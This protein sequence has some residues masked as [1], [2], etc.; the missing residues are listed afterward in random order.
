MKKPLHISI[1]FI[2]LLLPLIVTPCLAQDQFITSQLCIGGNNVDVANNILLIPGGGFLLTGES[3]SKHGDFTG[4]HGGEDF[5]VSWLK[6]NGQLKWAKQYG[7]SGDDVAF[8]AGN[9]LNG[10]AIAGITA[11]TDKD[12]IG[13]H[14]SNDGWLALLNG[15]GALVT[16]KC[17]GGSGSDQFFDM[18]KTGDGGLLLA[19]QAIST[20][21]DLTNAGANGSN[22]VWLLKLDANAN[23]E[24]S[25]CFGG[26]GA[27]FCRSAIQTSDGNYVAACYSRSNDG[28][29]T[30][31]YGPVYNSDVWVIKVDQSGNLLWSTLLG[32][33][34][35][36]YSD[37]LLEDNEGNIWMGGQSYSA[38]FDITDHHGSMDVWVVKLASDGSKISSTSFGGSATDAFEGG[39]IQISNN[40]FM[41]AGNTVSTELYNHHGSYDAWLT[42][43]DSDGTFISDYCYGGSKSDFAT[44]LA[45]L[46]GGKFAMCGRTISFNGDVSG[47][48]GNFDKWFLL[49]DDE[50]KLQSPVDQNSQFK[51]YPIPAI[52]KITIECPN[53]FEYQNATVTVFDIAGRIVYKDSFSIS[54]TGIN[55]NQWKAGIYYVRVKDGI[56]NEVIK[57]IRE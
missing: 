39:L 1:A 14:G 30:E 9:F 51:L 18:V 5:A 31:H 10:F 57:M 21:G 48:H 54:N 17:F 22:E 6:Q 36:D 35:D 8:A 37:D 13:N 12:V 49:F 29:F 28:D 56:Y 44:D 41:V 16:S 52:D 38:D 19:G 27:D 15:N 24:W 33:S 53:D 7:G 50:L 20:D 47:A 2:S 42:N 43:F 32:G 26:S 11:S 4:N 34:S 23:I 3:E 40:H 45:A 55:V 25:K 46:N